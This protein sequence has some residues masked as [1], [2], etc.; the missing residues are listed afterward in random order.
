MLEFATEKTAVIV[1]K[2]SKDFFIAAL[3]EMN[4]EAEQ[5]IMV[6]DDIGKLYFITII[7]IIKGQLISKCH[8]EK[9]V[10]S[11]I[12]TKKIPRFLS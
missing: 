9:S 4:L 5:A 11:K 8:Y 6:G 12:P 7:V 3:N 1:G 10:L 2:P